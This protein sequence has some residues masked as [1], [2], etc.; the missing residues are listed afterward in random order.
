L[1]PRDARYL[2]AFAVDGC[3][4]MSLR[5]RWCRTATTSRC[6]APRT[7][8]WRSAPLGRRLDC[9]APKGVHR[10]SFLFRHRICPKSAFHFSVRCLRAE[11]GLF[12]LCDVGAF[13]PDE[14]ATARDMKPAIPSSPRCLAKP[15]GRMGRV[16]DRHGW[17]RPGICS[18]GV[19]GLVSPSQSFDRADWTVF[20]ESDRTLW[21]RPE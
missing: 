13:V 21:R 16:Q 1:R 9:R 11:A 8:I 4:P 17:F 14:P 15:P 10:S 12:G 19:V 20:Y 7:G 5:C 2:A 18:G 6:P 3:V